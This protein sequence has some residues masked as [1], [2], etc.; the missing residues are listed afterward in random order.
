MAYVAMTRRNNERQTHMKGIKTNY[1]HVVAP[2][3]DTNVVSVADIARSLNMNPKHVR[4]RLRR[5]YKN[6]DVR[7]KE[8]Q[9]IAPHVWKFDVTKVDV[10]AVRAL[11]A[12]FANDDATES[13]DSE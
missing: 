8:L 13:D 12:S 1:T 9:T 6:N 2:T 3:S 11:I 7:V 10:N 4:A 5:M